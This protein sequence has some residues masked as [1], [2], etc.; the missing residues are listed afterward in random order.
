MSS[1]RVLE[2]LIGFVLFAVC[3]FLIGVFSQKWGPE[4][5]CIERL[6]DPKNPTG[7]KGQ[8]CKTEQVDFWQTSSDQFVEFGD[9]Q[10]DVTHYLKIAN[11]FLKGPDL[12]NGEVS[13]QLRWALTNWAPGVPFLISIVMRTLGGERYFVKMLALISF[14]F[15]GIF[16]LLSESMKNL[17]RT[18]WLRLSIL[19]FLFCLPDFR[20]QTLGFGYIVSEGWATVCFLLALTLLHRAYSSSDKKSPLM[21]GAA[22]ALCSYC[23]ALLDTLISISL[24]GVICAGLVRFLLSR[25]LKN[26]KN[27]IPTGGATRFFFTS[28]IIWITHSS[29]VFPW[30]FKNWKATNKYTMCATSDGVYDLT[31]QVNEK[32]PKW[33]STTNVPCRLRPG[34]CEELHGLTDELWR[35]LRKDMTK[36]FLSMNFLDWTL[37]RAGDF[38]LLWTNYPYR[39]I[40]PFDWKWLAVWAEGLLYLFAGLFW[41]VNCF[42]N[43]GAD[44]AIGKARGFDGFLGVFILANLTVFLVAPYEHRY[45]LFLRLGLFYGGYL[46]LLELRQKTS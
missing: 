44:C 37:F 2:N 3:I 41:L 1:R 42:T 34:L 29:L 20:F 11:Y 8:F 23:R 13:P 38:N 46:S 12:P 10:G 9:G 28:L 39:P 32:I 18:K 45:S 26:E 4:K 24:I 21:A 30:K 14:A 27:R 35:D 33:I 16:L 17:I 25:R 43:R 31:W 6:V 40:A 36:V 19:I 7:A 22:L 5:T 15:A